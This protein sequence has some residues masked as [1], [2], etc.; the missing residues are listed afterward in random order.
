MFYILVRVQELAEQGILP[1]RY[2]R[3][4]YGLEWCI[5]SARVAGTVVMK[6]RELSVEDQLRMVFDAA[7]DDPPYDDLPLWLCRRLGF[8][9]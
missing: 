3:A 6:I 9:Q 4:A 1:W 5:G 7:K 8:I 2:L